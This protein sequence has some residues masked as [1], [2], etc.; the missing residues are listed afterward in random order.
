ML[1]W[2]NVFQCTA[3]ATRRQSLLVQQAAELRKMATASKKNATG[4]LE[5][6]KNKNLYC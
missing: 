3:G 2:G 6:I 5:K 1:H 4:L